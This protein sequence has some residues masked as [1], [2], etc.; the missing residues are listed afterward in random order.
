MESDEKKQIQEELERIQKK[1]QELDAEYKPLERA[2]RRC[3]LII[4]CL[5]IIALVH[6]LLTFLMLIQG[7]EGRLMVFP[8]AVLL[9]SAIWLLHINNSPNF[10]KLRLERIRLYGEKEILESCLAD[11]V[12]S[13]EAERTTD[14]YR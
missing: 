6:M 9:S 4:L 2:R 13:C 8:V 10:S 7:M 1:I 5:T 14:N 3:V 11:I 12:G